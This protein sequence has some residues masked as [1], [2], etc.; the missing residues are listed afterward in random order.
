MKS[1]SLR[2]Y[3]EYK[4]TAHYNSSRHSQGMLVSR[5]RQMSRSCPI[6]W[7]MFTCLLTYLLN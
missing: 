2:C 4:V 7:D 3:T 5:W 1:F 6:H